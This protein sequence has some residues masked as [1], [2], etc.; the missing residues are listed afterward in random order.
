MQHFSRK[1][2]KAGQDVSGATSNTTNGTSL[3]SISPYP[4]TI[5]T[6]LASTNGL[7]MVT[8]KLPASAPMCQQSH[9]S[10]SG[11]TDVQSLSTGT[12]MTVA[13]RPRRITVAGDSRLAPFVLKPALDDSLLDDGS[14][15]AMAKL[16]LFQQC[17]RSL[18][19]RSE[20]SDTDASP[21]SRTQ[22]AA[23]AV[24]SETLTSIKKTL[25]QILV[26]RKF[27]RKSEQRQP[28]DESYIRREIRQQRLSRHQS[29]GSAHQ[30][31]ASGS[32][33]RH[34]SKEAS[35]AYPITRSRQASLHQLPLHRGASS[36]SIRNNSGSVPT[37]DRATEDIRRQKQERYRSPTDGDELYPRTR[38]GSQDITAGMS[39]HADHYSGEHAGR[40]GSLKGLFTSEHGN[41]GTGQGG[42]Y[43]SPSDTDGHST[44]NTQDNSSGHR[45]SSEGA[46][47]AAG[48]Y[49]SC[50]EYDM[51]GALSTSHGNGKQRPT[52]LYR[53]GSSIS[54]LS[55][56]SSGNTAGPPVLTVADITPRASISGYLSTFQVNSTVFFTR[57]V[58]KRRY[59]LLAG[60]E[61][62]RFKSS[63]PDCPAT[64]V[65]KLTP[66]SVVCVSEEF[67]GT[68][69]CM[70]ISGATSPLPGSTSHPA[71]SS[72]NVSTGAPQH[73]GTANTM[74]SAA[75]MPTVWEK[76]V[77]SGCRC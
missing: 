41:A 16:M 63:E 71:S 40:R 50:V 68:Q 21:S 29:L 26:D 46:S 19:S 44:L 17:M 42:Q 24:Y 58:W 48:T 31:G 60:H 28:A 36:R 59:Y 57:R 61:L 76:V 33:L 2:D 9:S 30:S 51:R 35:M 39:G 23:P 69:Y 8:R 66:T 37:F 13:T 64:D 10:T 56:P 43:D 49:Q 74:L 65:L 11:N 53:H 47:T 45:I 20:T 52:G 77:C 4:L 1:S 5:D 25:D 14:A 75:T 67:P 12:K 38:H 32:S 18:S 22:I 27:E 15:M 70:E 72:T 6:Q 73:G 3:D 54:S 55:Q 62:Y 7:N 34:G